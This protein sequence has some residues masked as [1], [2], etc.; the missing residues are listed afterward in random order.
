[1]LVAVVIIT[2]VVLI[3][4]YARFVEKLVILPSNAFTVELP[5]F[6]VIV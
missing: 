5:K 6:T 2:V 3:N 4:L 1:M